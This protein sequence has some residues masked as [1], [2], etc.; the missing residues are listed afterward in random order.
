MCVLALILFASF[1]GG[2]IAS[3]LLGHNSNDLF[4]YSAN[5]AEQP[6]GPL[7]WVP[8]LNDAIGNTADGELTPPT[9][10][11]ATTLFVLGADGPL[12]RDELLRVL[13]GGKTSLEIAIGGMLMALLIGVPL[14]ALAGYFGGLGDA[15]VSRL[16]EWVMAFPLMLFLIFASVQLDK[17]LTPIAWGNV[18]PQGLFAEALLIGVFTSFYPTRLVR[19]QLLQ[20]RNAEFVES[21]IMVGA[22]HWRVLRRH[23]LPHLLPTLLVWGA[24]AIATNLLLEVGL[25]FIGA[26]VQ[27]TTPTWGSLLATTWGTFL[28]PQTYNSQNFTPWQTICPS[29]AMLLAVVSL[30]QLS[31]G[32]RRALDPWASR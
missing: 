7:T 21:A 31:E 10:G 4:P 6:V 25:S 23:L 5:I 9:K 14:G 2:P 3:R 20:L 30:N 8:D 11:T 1:A 24:I 13:E 32:L 22:S 18:F 28:Q 26:G 12:G 29:V 19:A 17:V 27:P 15:V 16:T